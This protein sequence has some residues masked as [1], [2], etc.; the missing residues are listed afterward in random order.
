MDR[1][2]GGIL[3]AVF[4]AAAVAILSLH[5]GG[6]LSFASGSSVATN[7]T[8]P[9]QGGTVTSLSSV[10]FLS[11]FAGLNGPAYLV[12]FTINGQG[13]SLNGT[14]G[15]I[16][17]GIN[18]SYSTHA[19]NPVS[20]TYAL[21]NESIAVRYQFQGTKLYAWRYVP[22]GIDYQNS[23]CGFG[24]VCSSSD[25]N[26]ST[27]TFA[28]GTYLGFNTEQYLLQRVDAFAAS[29][30]SA[31]VSHPT[32]V[33][34][35]QAAG[36]A[37]GSVSVELGCVA[38]FQVPMATIYQPYSQQ[39][40]LNASV[41]FTNSSYTCTI[42]LSDM[43][44]SGSCGSTVYAQISG[45]AMSSN[46]MPVGYPSVADFY[47]NASIVNTSLLT[48]TYKQINQLP[49]SSAL[50][51][52]SD[53]Y[54]GQFPSSWLEA[55]L[56]IDGLT[57]Q[58]VYSLSQLSDSIASQNSN[59]NTF[60]YQPQNYTMLSRFDPSDNTGYIDVSRA[61]IEY[62]EVQLVAKLATLSPYIP[63]AK[64]IITG[65]T[66]SRPVFQ[67]GSAATLTF[68]VYNNASAGASF[69]I[70][71]ACGN[72]TFSA[73]PVYAQPFAS[74]TVPVSVQSPANPGLN[75][76]VAPCSATAYSSSYSIFSSTFSFNSTVRPN[77]PSNYKYVNS[78]TCQPIG[79][80]LNNT[81]GNQSANE[82]PAGYEFLNGV[83]VAVN[84]C[85]VGYFEN[86]T[87][88]PPVCEPISSPKNGGANIYAIVLFIAIVAGLAFL[89]GRRRRGS[90]RRRTKRR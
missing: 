71:G 10:K 29:C 70:S 33:Y 43:H 42:P 47:P 36:S 16:A 45:Y 32:T 49:A 44:D 87:V 68:T 56:V 76:L 19:D 2:G 23:T 22:V 13:Q 51:A 46:P 8:A 54:T 18:S 27:Y 80:T 4:I 3:L 50:L 85:P 15:S 86:V 63:V 82:C 58:N 69:G 24:F 17:Q 1:K 64:P 81:G 48:G 25:P 7:S 66:P 40:K 5:L 30:A 79:P 74:V 11:N 26:A 9:I 77:C 62:P 72:S 55:N 12:G 60:L 39:L 35:G 65:V 6:Y 78:L 88:S 38:P 57:V 83:C 14:Q 90:R 31:P 75:N 84:N 59:L 21:E 52:D 67:S 28:V 34:I 37:F 89:G 41:T 73:Q 61:P 20:I 53:T